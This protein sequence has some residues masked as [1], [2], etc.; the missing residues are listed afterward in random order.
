MTKPRIAAIVAALLVAAG[1]AVAQDY[2]NIVVANTVVARIRTGGPYGSL[3]AREARIS[4]SIVEALSNELPHI[5]SRA[6]DGPALT[7][8]QV[9]GL[10]TLS[11]GNTMLIQAYPEDAVGTTP[12]AL[13]AQWKENFRRQLPR[14]V[15]P[16]KV[17]QWWKDT[18]PDQIGSPST[19]GH[20]LPEVDVPLVGEVVAIMDAARAMSDAEFE[21]L[22]GNVQRAIL[23][24]IWSYRRPGCEAPPDDVYIR[25]RSALQKAREAD[26]ARWAAEKYMVAGITITKT[27]EHY[28]IPEGMGPV[29]EQREL[30]DFEGGPMPGL[31][32]EPGGPPPIA[33]PQFVPDIPIRQALLGTGLDAQNRILNVGQEFGAVLTQLLVYLEVVGAPPNTVI[34][35]TVHH[36]DDIVGHRL[37]R[38]AGEQKL[39]VTFYPAQVVEV[40]PGGD[41][42]CQF[43]INGENV[44]LIPFRVQP[45][46]LVYEGG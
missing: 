2:A 32:G 6:H 28:C 45:S 24:Y 4:Q 12:K 41:Y 39:A 29:P 5:F 15:A 38:V 27:R 26:E 17:P 20:G 18:H 37:L 7:V 25:I 10:W 1:M 42:E 11:I 46:R 21:R 30:P 13:I 34:G 3:Y 35:V 31:P 19:A 23:E 16:S 36:G 8:S 40:F 44:G 22:E 9:G 14:A 33:P 43:T